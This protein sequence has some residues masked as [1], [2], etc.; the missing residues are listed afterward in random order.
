MKTIQRSLAAM[1]G[2]AVA[3][4]L[5]MQVAHA[6]AEVDVAGAD[7]RP[8]LGDDPAVAEIDQ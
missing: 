5:S 1:A 6:A 2:A 3:L 8:E 7:A 4:L